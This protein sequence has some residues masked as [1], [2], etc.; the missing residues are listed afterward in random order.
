MMVKSNKALTP[1]RQHSTNVLRGVQP[2]YQ[3]SEWLIQSIFHGTIDRHWGCHCQV[4]KWWR[5]PKLNH[6]LAML[7]DIIREALPEVKKVTSIRTACSAM[8]SSAT[9]ER[10]FS[11][12]GR[13]FTIFHSS[14]TEK[15]QNNCMILHIHKELLDNMDLHVVHLAKHFVSLNHKRMCYFGT[16]D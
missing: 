11:T 4:C 3:W 10:A 2:Y 8:L 16:Y 5:L 6:H 14:M 15:R 9:H 7:N 13:I 12:L 1:S